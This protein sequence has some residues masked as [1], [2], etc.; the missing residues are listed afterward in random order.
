MKNIIVVAELEP[1]G[2]IWGAFVALPDKVQQYRWG[3][4]TADD[5]KIH[6]KHKHAKIENSHTAWRQQLGRKHFVIRIQAFF[7]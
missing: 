7:E 2:F 6:A 4:L 3:L 5:E 1:D